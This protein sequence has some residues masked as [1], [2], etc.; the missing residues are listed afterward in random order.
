[1]ANFF[2]GF[3]FV[4]AILE[5]EMKKQGDTWLFT[6]LENVRAYKTL[7]EMQAAEPATYDFLVKFYNYRYGTGKWLQ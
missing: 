7:K 5:V 6:R 4:P 2:S 3:G 1:M